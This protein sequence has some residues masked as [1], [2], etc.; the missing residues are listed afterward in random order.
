MRILLVDDEVRL[1]DGIRRGLEAEGMVVDV[2][3]NGVDGVRLATDGDYDAI[4]LDV[5]MPGMSG[6]RVC[7]SLRA[8]DV[9]T[10]VLF[11][12]A[13]DGEWDE[14]EGLDTGGDDWLTKPFSHPVLV[15]RIRALVRRGGRAR[16]PVLI[17]GDLRLDPAARRAFRGDVELSLTARELS[18]LDYLLRRRG[19][20][21]TR[22]EVI[23]NVWGGDFD[24]DENIVEV[25]IAHLRA[26][27]DKPFGR[28]S[29]ETVRGTGY[30]LS[31]TG[32]V[33]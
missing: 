22:R 17:A 4:V 10:P 7:Q 20:A 13:K 15:A 28:E 21:V 32:G 29:I 23:A 2:A 25:Y 16:P 11:L 3:H 18:V 1:A 30:R 26:K 27:I 14:V 9:W 12:T 8:D 31:G 33:R 5:M 6:Y 24:G 19:E